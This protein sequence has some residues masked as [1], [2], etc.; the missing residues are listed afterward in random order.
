MLMSETKLMPVKSF[1]D[2]SVYQKAYSLALA[3]HKES[4]LLPKIEQYGG[5]A[6]QMRRASKSICAN[7]AEGF[8]KQRHSSPE[9]KRFIS[10]A[11][12][13]ADE[14]KVWL[15]FCRDLTYFSESQVQA[16]RGDYVS[17]AKMLNGLREKWS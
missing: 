6:D 5:L 12:G 11:I 1:E 4:L 14:M 15:Q 17:I 8:A 10:I 16:W 3:I 2:L 13:S 9:F 7:I